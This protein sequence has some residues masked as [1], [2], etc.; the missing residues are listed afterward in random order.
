MNTLA[1]MKTYPALARRPSRCLL[2]LR[3][4]QD[5]TE[6]MLRSRDPDIGI[7]GGKGAKTAN[8]DMLKQAQKMMDEGVPHETIRNRTGWERGPE[9]KWR[10][11]ISDAEARIK[12]EHPEDRIYEAD[13]ASRASGFRPNQRLEQQLEHPAA[14]EAYPWLKDMRTSLDVG[15]KIKPAA[16]YAPPT[17][18]SLKG[19]PERCR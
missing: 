14:Y 13:A 16:E 12:P 17:R 2:V 19:L 11:E 6:R 9:G 18:Y 10:F 8:L 4:R 7:F 3:L 5:C 15:E 1:V